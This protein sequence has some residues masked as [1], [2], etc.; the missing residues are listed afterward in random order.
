MATIMFQATASILPNPTFNQWII[1]IVIQTHSPKLFQFKLIVRNYNIQWIN[2]NN[3]D[4][5]KFHY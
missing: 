1:T 5:H 2:L 4:K 3:L